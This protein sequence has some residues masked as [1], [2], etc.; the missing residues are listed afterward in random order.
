MPTL[1]LAVWLVITIGVTKRISL[2]VLV[3]E[4]CVLC[5][6]RSQAVMAG[7]TTLFPASAW[8]QDLEVTRAQT[9]K[10]ANDKL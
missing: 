5:N 6:Q 1:A 2:D 4:R 7:S 3:S 9:K 8:Q 10:H